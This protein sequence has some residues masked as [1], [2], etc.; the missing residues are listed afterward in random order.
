MESKILEN[1]VERI[2]G[3]AVRHT[4]SDDEADELSQEILLTALK[5]LPKLRDESRFETVALGNRK[6]YRT[7]FQ[8]LLRQDAHVC[9]DR[10]YRRAAGA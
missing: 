7:R 6:K 5:Q 2:Y 3:W 10:P 8:T 9:L 1:Y 4:F